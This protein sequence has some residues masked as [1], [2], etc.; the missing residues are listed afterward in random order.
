MSKPR[1]RQRQVSPLEFFKHL[2]WIDGRPLL[3]VIEPYRRDIFMRA[4]YTFE[5]GR[6]KFNRVVTGRG[7]KNWKTTDLVLAGAYCFFTLKS[8]QGND[9]AIVANDEDQAD[10]DFDLLKK[11]IRAN[12]ILLREVTILQKQIVRKDGHGSFVILPA[13]DVI[14]LHGKSFAFIGYDEIHGYRNYD[15][16][17]AL[18]PDPTRECIEWIT[19][20]ASIYHTPGAPLYDMIQ[21]GKRGDDPHM[22][23]SW[24]AADYTT[25]LAAEHLD[26]E[27]KANPSMASWDSPAYLAQQKRRLPSHKYRRLHLN[28][29]GLPDGTYFDAER[30]NACTVE[31]RRHLKPQPGIQYV[32]FVDMC[33]G[34]NDDAAQAIAHHDATTGRAVLDLVITQTGR[35]PFNPR[36]AVRKFAAVCK[37]YGVF[38]VIG[39][40]YAGETFRADFQGEGISY[41]VS[42]LTKHQLYEALEPRLNAGE[43]E[44]LDVPKLQEQLLGLVTRGGKIDHLPGEHDDTINAAAGALHFARS[45][46]AVDV[47][48]GSYVPSAEERQAVL[49][50]HIRELEYGTG[51]TA[52]WD[53]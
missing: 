22:F 23:F 18:A 10:D 33:G 29:P 6:R 16:L 3:E 14:G 5:G 43:I 7:K 46:L 1:L 25:D 40:R 8:A 34:S 49:D 12:P 53:L 11:I 9:C 48:S 35:P 51:R 42:P 20:Y 45:Q 17:E 32:G 4:L 36:D 39:D 21:A 19:S 37:E 50:A 44:L 30:V 41:Q 38:R 28:L 47:A 24:Y 2:R 31:G 13:R 15:V 26:P 27:A 52:P